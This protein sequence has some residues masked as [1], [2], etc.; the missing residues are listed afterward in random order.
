[1]VD[2]S[3]TIFRDI[4]TSSADRDL[5]YNL[6]ASYFIDDTWAGE[7][8]TK[9][10]AD[11]LQR[12]ICIFMSTVSA[13]PLIYEPVYLGFYEPGHH[14][15]VVSCLGTLDNLPQFT[16]ITSPSNITTS[17]TGM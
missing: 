4:C 1:M 10:A 12:N 9:V 7:N 17:E 8:I 15:A 16:I 2:Y 11:Y 14:R 3:D 5:V 6:A 13:S